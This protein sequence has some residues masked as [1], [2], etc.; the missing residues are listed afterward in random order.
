MKYLLFVL[1]VGCG[2]VH[3]MP[4]G[5]G[6]PQ[7]TGGIALAGSGGA[8]AAGGA[9][10]ASP[11]STGGTAVAGTGGAGGMDSAGAGGALVAGTGG[12]VPR[13]IDVI[14]LPVC[15]DYVTEFGSPISSSPACGMSEDGHLLYGCVGVERQG[16]P[17]DAT[18]CQFTD[19]KD[20]Y[21]GSHVFGCVDVHGC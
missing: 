16:Y 17:L 6:E 15:P 7:G 18:P 3:G 13:G 4:F 9:S 5:S 14:A 2:E 11:G 19:P 20:Q 12:V 8:V 21:N 1:L 10:G